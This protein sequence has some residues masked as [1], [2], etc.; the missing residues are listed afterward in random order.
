MKEKSVSTSSLGGSRP[1]PG[2]TLESLS[3]KNFPKQIQ[4]SKRQMK[5]PVKDF[6]NQTYKDKSNAGNLYKYSRG[7]KDEELQRNLANYELFFEKNPKNKEKNI[8]KAFHTN[9]KS[10]IYVQNNYKD[11]NAEILSKILD[12]NEEFAPNSPSNLKIYQNELNQIQNNQKELN[13]ESEQKNYL[14]TESKEINNDIYLSA[15]NETLTLEDPVFMGLQLNEKIE[16]LL[17]LTT[18]ERRPARLGSVVALYLICKKYSNEIDEEH[19]GII[20]EKIVSLLQTYEKQEELFLVACLE[21]CSLYGY[22]DILIENIGLICMFITDFNFPKLQKA[23]FNCL[24][25]LEYDGIRTL[26][27]LASKDYQDYQSYILNCLIQ[28]PHIQK[29][30]IIRALLNE[31]YSNSAQRRNIALSAI[32]RMHELVNDIDTL[33][34]IDSFFNEPKIKKDFIAS[35]LRTAGPEGEIILLNEIKSNKD[36]EVR[37]AIAN[38]FSYRI[39]KNPKYLKMKLDKNDTYA[40][41]NNL[42]G[43]FCKYHG[44]ISPVI[45]MNTKQIEDLLEE[46]EEDDEI[47]T[48]ENLQNQNE[49]EYL[50]VNTRDFLAALQ[51]MLSMNY[52]HE[53]PQLVHNR[54]NNYNTLDNLNIHTTQ[55]ENNENEN[56]DEEEQV[57]ELSNYETLNKYASFFELP[58]NDNPNTSND[59]LDENGNYLVTEDI[60]KA[61]THCLKDYSPKVRESAATSLG[62]IGL[63]ESLLAID[64]LIDN[65][66]DE[67]VNVRSKIIYAIGKVAPGA[68]SSYIPFLI[69]SVQNNM[70]KVK[71]ASLFAL[72][73]YGDRAAKNSLPYLVKLLKESSINKNIIAQTIVKLGL[74]GE[75]VLLKIMSN[76]PDSNYK[77]KAAIVHSL[78]YTDITSTNI[79]FIVECIFRQGKNSYSLVR[80]SAIFSIRVL[81]EKADEKIT[82][83]KRKNIIPFYYDKLKDKDTN[84]QS[85]AI[86]CI[87]ALGPQGELI[88]IE[89]FTKDP[90]PIIRTNCGIGLA[91][92]GVH[93]LRTLLIGLHDENDSVRN[94]IEKLIVVKMDINNVIQYFGDNGQLLSLKI[95]V[96]DIL[97]KNKNLSMFTVNYF[98]QLISAIERYEME[99]KDNINS[100]ENKVS[101][102]D[103]E[104]IDN[105]E[106]NMIESEGNNEQGQQYTS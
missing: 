55:K 106:N 16:K 65:I 102:Q 61:L 22:C 26:V 82:Y 58:S 87:K 21:I 7:I 8:L 34:K 97:E 75:G 50:E 76:E 93:T 77:L 20:I 101:E 98:N 49:D 4:N 18:D 86:N 43:S 85:Y 1:S 33:E 88:F 84:I 25:N 105:M 79:D 70:W 52:D 30:I 95:S 99:N 13:T 28:T 9:N 71:K 11:S 51:R 66:N 29:I 92:S 78:A 89:G 59:I 44:K 32:N 36:F 37:R 39:P 38:S 23:T 90:N 73:Q 47:K 41:S 94:T 81:A 63:P 45:E 104:N 69:D 2:L 100:E 68:D 53:N 64:G 72:S 19:K 80:R 46:E 91:E 35:I 24:M 15:L 10:D 48:E 83:L 12:S 56:Q 67:D 27:D 103:G 40:N 14:N 6:K 17:Q 31:V 3:F 60:I 42:P 54:E 74:E 62:I 57:N 5:A 96:K